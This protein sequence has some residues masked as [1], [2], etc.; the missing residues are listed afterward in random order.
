MNRVL[1]SV[2]QFLRLCGFDPIMS[3]NTFKGLPFY[4]ND[5][6]KLKKQK[7]KDSDFEFGLNYPVLDERFSKSGT[8]TGHY[9]HQDLFV[10][11]KIYFEN[12]ERHVDIGSRTDGFVAHV[13]VFREI[14]IIDIREQSRKVRNILSGKQI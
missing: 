12:P 5:F 3:F 6:L 1:K 14:E 2:Y 11:N 8:M 4:I 10:A 13:A 7:G 9:F